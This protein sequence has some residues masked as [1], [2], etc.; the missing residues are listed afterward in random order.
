VELKQPHKV[1]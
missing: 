1:A